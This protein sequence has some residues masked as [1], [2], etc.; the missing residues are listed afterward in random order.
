MA[1]VGNISIQRHCRRSKHFLAWP[2]E[3][4]MLLNAKAPSYISSLLSHRKSFR[5]LRYSDQT[6]SLVKLK[7]Y[8]DRTLC[9][10]APKLWKNLHLS[11]RKFALI[12]I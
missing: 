4:K 8:G 6:A 1:E 12:A 9:I 2:R 11:I 5:S 7:T 10:V 3:K